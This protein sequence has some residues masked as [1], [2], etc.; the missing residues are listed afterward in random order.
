M[1][2]LRTSLADTSAG[3]AAAN[4]TVD[5]AGGFPYGAF[6]L[7]LKTGAVANGKVTGG[8]PERSPEPPDRVSLAVPARQ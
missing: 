1:M 3:H 2:K 5:I 4:I 7:N 6:T 8:G